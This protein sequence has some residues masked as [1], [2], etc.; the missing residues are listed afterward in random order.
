MNTRN[1]LTACLLMLGLLTACHRSSTVPE[2]AKNDVDENGY[3]NGTWVDYFD[4]DGQRMTR[5]KHFK[6]YILS[7]WEH[8]KPVFA[9]TEYDATGQ[10]FRKARFKSDTTLYRP[11][12]FPTVLTG[13]EAILLKNAAKT[14]FDKGIRRT[15]NDDGNVTEEAFYFF[16]DGKNISEEIIIQ[17]TYY[18]KQHLRSAV[19]ITNNGTVA[20]FHY[21]STLVFTSERRNEFY[22][23]YYQ[24]RLE[25]MIRTSLMEVHTNNAINKPLVADILT[26]I[27][28]DS[29]TLFRL[30]DG[31]FIGQPC[32]YAEQIAQ[33][34]DEWVNAFR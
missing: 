23:T 6:T 12:A 17:K 29:S 21:D 15:Y 11:D 9:F 8:G 25:T 2:Q 1:F 10:L 28:S 30:V 4:A 27:W 26:G 7:E 32:P 20:S 16:E 18:K 33:A 19:V 14:G 34:Y 3:R 22:A 24:P 13:E 31:S 5:S